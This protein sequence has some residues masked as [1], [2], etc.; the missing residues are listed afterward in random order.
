M[1]L[2]AWL[3]AF[4]RAQL[5]DVNNGNEDAAELG[6]P[7]NYGL[8]NTHNFYFRCREFFIDLLIAGQR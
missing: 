2:T 8:K 1:W 5:F 3:G 4:I 6:E 7:S